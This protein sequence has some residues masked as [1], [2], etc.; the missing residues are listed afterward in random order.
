MLGLNIPLRKSTFMTIELNN[1][2]LDQPVVI[3][4][5]MNGQTIATLQAVFPLTEA[6]Y[7]RLKGGPPITASAAVMIFSGVVGYAIA[8]GPK[9]QSIISGEQS[10]LSYGE[11]KTIGAWTLI[12][13]VIYAIG[14]LIPNDRT[15]IMKRLHGH[16][17]V[18]KSSTHIIGGG[19]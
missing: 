19:K 1:Q 16:F 4:D 3:A 18:A 12:S 15:N 9:L 17:K 8:L 14:W 13:V 2:K 7:L 11:I 10:L 6:D 5:V